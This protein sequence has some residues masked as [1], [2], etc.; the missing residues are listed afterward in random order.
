MGA[1]EDFQGQARKGFETLREA[2]GLLQQ[3]RA[4]TAEALSRLRS[5][6]E[7]TGNERVDA[8]AARLEEVA[9]ELNQAAGHAVGGAEEFKAYLVLIGAEGAVGGDEGPSIGERPAAGAAEREPK[10]LKDFNPKT[11]HPDAVRD[12]AGAGWPRNRDDNIS[13]RANV[14]DEHG[15]QLNDEPLTP[16]PYRDGPERPELKP[17]WNAPGM[18]TSWHVESKLAQ[19]IR[20]SG[21]QTS[22]VYLNVRRCGS[23]RPGDERPAPLGC[24]ENFRHIIPRDSIVY[25]HVIQENGRTMTQRV[26]GTGEGIK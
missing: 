26:I 18:T 6:T 15:T 24:T 4:K 25:V 1:F 19:H 23:A 9:E 12:L 22:S 21:A 13:A 10:R 8:S 3:A 14:Y 20:D 5:A 2:Y 11:I 16:Y 7:G 17:R